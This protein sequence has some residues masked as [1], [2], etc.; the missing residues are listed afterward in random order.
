MG[1]VLLF[2]RDIFS[3]YHNNRVKTDKTQGNRRSNCLQTE[4]F[5]HLVE[6]RLFLGNLVEFR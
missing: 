4:R 6:D 5:Q 2:T 1:A 3:R